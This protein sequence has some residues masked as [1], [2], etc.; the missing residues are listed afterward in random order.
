M[1]FND[2]KLSEDQ[3]RCKLKERHPHL[4]EE[5]LDEIIPAIAAGAVGAL[6]RGAATVG[7]K[8]V[9]TLG[10]AALKGAGAVGKSIA[11]SAAKG[12]GNLAKSAAKG[13]VKGIAKGA[14][15][16]VGGAIGQAAMGQNNQ[17]MGQQLQRGK[18]I[19]LPTK[20]GKPAEFKVDSMTGKEVTLKN[21]KPRPG[22]PIKTVHKK[23]DILSQIGGM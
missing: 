14:A 12:A 11:K 5:Q 22:E 21:P 1:R 17:N 7:A 15:Q 3:I 23:D 8:A 13:A 4:T 18:I 10:K 6:A 20:D 16:A 2:I 19:T 9:G